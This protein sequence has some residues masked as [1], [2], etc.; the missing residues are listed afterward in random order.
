[1]SLFK[2]LKAQ[3][4]DW[5]SLKFRQNRRMYGLRAAVWIAVAHRV[6]KVPYQPGSRMITRSPSGKKIILRYGTSDEQVFQGVFL[7][8]EF[9]FL[10]VFKAGDVVSILDL[11]ANSGCTTILLA[12]A[13]PNA[14]VIAVEPD[15]D[16]FDLL[17][18]N[19]RDFGSRVI[20][21]NKAVW[22]EQETLGFSKSPYRGGGHWARRVEPA[23]TMDGN[24][25]VKCTTID[26]IMIEHCLKSLDIL[27]VD[28]EGAEI[29]VL[30]HG[31]KWLEL[32]SC[33]A[34]ELHEDTP[35]GSAV[36]LFEER[37]PASDFE[38]FKSGEK[39]VAM[40]IPLNPVV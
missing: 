31:G 37:F 4:R 20:C 35:F 30:Q 26:D 5:F 11:G 9:L 2:T 19:T 21:V 40:R 24:L 13:F 14:T 18:E 16:S 6:G 38:I 27:K 7:S 29:S 12:S 8:T 33:V 22:G 32:L 34:I 25:C 36:K 1:M 10:S 3:L 39:R 17:V 23:D 28:I 15:V